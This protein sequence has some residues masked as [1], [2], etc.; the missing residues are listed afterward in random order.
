MYKFRLLNGGTLYG[1]RISIDG[2][3][4]RIVSADSEPVIPYEVDDVILHSAERF[5]VEVDIPMDMMN[6]YTLESSLQGYQVRS[7]VCLTC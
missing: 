3:R 4:L 5:D 6:R 1:F 2:L 7:F